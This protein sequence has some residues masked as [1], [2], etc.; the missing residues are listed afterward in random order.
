MFRLLVQDRRIVVLRAVL[1]IAVGRAEEP[2]KQDEA[3]KE[4]NQADELPPARSAD[5]VE[6]AGVQGGRYKKYG[7]AGD[8]VQDEK[9]V[10]QDGP[11]Q[12]RAGNAGDEEQEDR[13]E[14]AED[15]VVAQPQRGDAQP[16]LLA[17]RAAGKGKLPF[18]ENYSG[19]F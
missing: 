19:V 9:G 6:T 1:V 18:P 8:E 14:Y 12:S 13:V 16:E 3:A 15:G 10:G 11:V 4:G 7:Q 5:V 2:E 17:G